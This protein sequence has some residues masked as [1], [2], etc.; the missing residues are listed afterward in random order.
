MEFQEEPVEAP[1]IVEQLQEPSTAPSETAPQVK[2]ARTR[3]LKAKP[4]TGATGGAQQKKS[5][6]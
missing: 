4:K 3:K 1:P 6:T 2:K 5:E